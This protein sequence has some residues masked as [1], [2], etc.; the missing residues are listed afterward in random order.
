VT[1]TGF[2]APTFTETGALP[3]GVTLTPSGLLTGTPTQSGDFPITI[4]AANAAGMVSQ[5]FTLTVTT[6]PAFAS[7][8]RVTFAVGTAGTFTVVVTGNPKPTLTVMGGALPPG[9]TFDPTTGAISGTPNAGT[10][11][12]HPLG[13][14]ATNSAG[15]TSQVLT[16]TVNEAPAIT[17]T[18][19]AE[20]VI[21][22]AGSFRA[23]A[24]GFPAPTFT[25][26]GALPMGVTLSPSGLLSGTPTQ[27]GTFLITLTATS[28]SG[29][30][31]QAFT[32]TVGTPPVITSANATTFTLNTAGNFQVTATGVPAPTFSETG[33]LPAGVTLSPAGVLSGTATTTGTFPITITATSSS[34]TTTQNF[35]LTVG[36]LPAITSPDTAAFTVGTAGHFHVTTAGF[37]APTLSVSGTLPP[38]LTF[39]PTAG[40]FTG[41]PT[42][43]GTFPVTVTA[44]NPLG[45]ATQTLNLTVGTSALTIT[46]ATLPDPVLGTAYSRQFAATGG[47]GPYTFT[48]TVGTLPT[49]L[50]LSPDGLL[51]GTPTE[52]GTF[53]FTVA[54]LDTA[55]PATGTRSYSLTVSTTPVP[56]KPSSRLTVGGPTDGTVAA[57][58]PT[59]SGQY[60]SSPTTTL[61]LFA[62]LGVNVRSVAADVDGDGI[63][64]V[65]MITGP[66]TPVRFAV[67]SGKDNTTVLVPPTDP[68]GGDFTGGGFV[69]AGDLDGDGRSEFVFTPDQGGG[70]NVVIYSLGTDGKLTTPKAFFALGNPGFRGG[71]RPAM[72]D[73]NGDGTPDLIVGAG[74]LGG[75]NVEIH[76][77]KAVARGDFA[78]LIGSGFFAFDGPDAQTLRN[79][80]FLAA[81]D[82]NG[83]GFADLIAGGGPGGGPRVLILDGKLLSTTGVVA[84]YAAPLANFFF[85]DPNSRGGVRVATVDA[86]GDNKAD[87]A[88]GSGEGLPSQVRVYFGKTIAPGG[89]P[90]GSQDLDPFGQVLPGG[91]FVG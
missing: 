28:S 72:G 79:G 7:P 80:V 34:G 61:N 67:V 3:M 22:T 74:F 6:P 4:T 91:V 18:N 59:T 2:P 52:T 69:A 75:P 20:F 62:G 46:P 21:G 35:T 56:P 10:G 15:T 89:E 31:S 66:G 86:D 29:T 36:S 43:A 71:A 87:V 26:T 14:F 8:D 85:G 32:L 84:A 1:A 82:V 58:D 37:P 11:G 65:V 44:M 70:P 53:N 48:V 5:T 42:G 38:G 64:D 78:T 50:S 77:G 12:D 73:I 41:T 63:P 83:D 27:S 33:A 49:G 23:T 30:A 9:L 90:S 54:A 88:V 24:T 57:F 68:F 25:E 19:T 17:S 13:I 81:G 51:S 40:A 55:R 39:D 16:L 47:T 45:V 76:D 60:P